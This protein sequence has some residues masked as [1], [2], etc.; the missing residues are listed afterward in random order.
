[1]KQLS[2]QIYLPSHLL[3]IAFVILS[4][5]IQ[6]EF[7]S[8]QHDYYPDQHQKYKRWSGLCFSVVGHQTMNQEVN[9]NPGQGYGFNPQC[10]SAG[11]VGWQPI[12]DSL[13]SR[14]FHCSLP[15]PLWN[16]IYLLLLKVQMIYIFDLE[17]KLLFEGSDKN[18][19]WDSS[20]FYPCRKQITLQQWVQWEQFLGKQVSVQLPASWCISLNARAW[21]LGL[22]LPHS[23]LGSLLH[24][25]TAWPPL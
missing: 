7:K 1:M 17:A 21:V 3:I 16:Y 10:G 25:K 19:W 5:H 6:M 8:K 20:E 18:K 12:D 22:T 4:S 14:Y 9:L 13:P 23:H 11:P 24:S 15:H 2:W